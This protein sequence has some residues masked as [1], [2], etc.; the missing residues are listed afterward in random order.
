[1]WKYN[2]G[3]S[4]VCK[5]TVLLKYRQINI[6][7]V[8]FDENVDLFWMFLGILRPDFCDVDWIK[9]LKDVLLVFNKT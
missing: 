1:M 2:I 8:D 6:F 3:R 4:V 7:I 9:V 5:S